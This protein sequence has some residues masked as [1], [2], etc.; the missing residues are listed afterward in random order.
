MVKCVGN[1]VAFILNISFQ[2]DGNRD[3]IML[4]HYVQL[5]YAFHPV[6]V[7]GWT[8]MSKDRVIKKIMH[9]FKTL[10]CLEV[11]I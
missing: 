10:L 6:R 8:H 3:E 2:S 9:N 11:E 5:V 4:Q 7:G 1:Y